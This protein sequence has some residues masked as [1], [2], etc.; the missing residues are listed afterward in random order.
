M[1]ATQKIRHAILLQ[2]ADDIPLPETID[3]SNVD[4][5]FDAANEDWGIQDYITDFREGEVETGLPAEY[6]RHYESKSVAAEMPDGSWVGW[7]FWFGGG[8]HGDP[9][10]IDWMSGAYDVEVY[11]VMEVVQK[12]SRVKAEKE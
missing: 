2:A 10:S 1:N 7:C 4:A 6:D 9:G 8:K 5:L 3:A 12:F 11:E